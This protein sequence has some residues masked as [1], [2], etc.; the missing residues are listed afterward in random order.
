M[1]GYAPDVSIEE[2]LAESAD[3]P[4]VTEEQ[5]PVTRDRVT[6]EGFAPEVDFDRTAHPEA[7]ELHSRPHGP[8]MDVELARHD[9]SP[10][11]REVPSSEEIDDRHGAHRGGDG[12]A[13]DSAVEHAYFSSARPL[14]PAGEDVLDLGSG[15]GDATDDGPAPPTAAG[16]GADANAAI[17]TAQLEESSMGIAALREALLQAFLNDVGP[18]MERLEEA[19]AESDGRRLEFEA[20]GLKGMSATIGATGCRQAFAELERAGRDDVLDSAAEWL[21][22]AR[23]E[24]DRA[25]RHILDEG[26]LNAA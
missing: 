10:S 12:F 8:Q 5:K 26:H 23:T 1:H 24:V 19:I 9:V 4:E 15:S 3:V 16:A 2:R 13:G 25:R 7:G 14:P 21:D 18:R 20:H 11:A 17:D 22:R 6:L